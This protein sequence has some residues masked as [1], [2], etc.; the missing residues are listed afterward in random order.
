MSEGRNGARAACRK[1]A[2]HRGCIDS[3]AISGKS[4]T[5]KASTSLLEDVNVTYAFLE[6]HAENHRSLLDHHQYGTD[7]EGRKAYLRQLARR[8]RTGEVAEHPTLSFARFR[9]RMSVLQSYHV[10]NGEERGNGPGHH[11]TLQARRTQSVVQM[12]RPTRT[13]RILPINEVNVECRSS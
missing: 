5:S 6:R 8:E 1:V 12:I 9:Q 11:Q 3:T 2:K 4:Y 10:V 13:R 7:I